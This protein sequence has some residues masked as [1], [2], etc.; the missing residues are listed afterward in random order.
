MRYIHAHTLRHHLCGKQSLGDLVPDVPPDQWRPNFRVG[1]PTFNNYNAAGHPYVLHF[2]L[3]FENY[4]SEWIAEQEGLQAAQKSSPDLFV[5]LGTFAKTSAD[6][7]SACDRRFEEDP[8]YEDRMV[9]EFG[10]RFGEAE[11]E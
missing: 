3:P 10:M 9:K 7:Q 5:P 8:Y 4:A 6:A 1:L 11:D 2:W